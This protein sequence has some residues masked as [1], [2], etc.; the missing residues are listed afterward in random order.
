MSTIKLIN[1]II[2]TYFMYNIPKDRSSDGLFIEV[3]TFII[4]N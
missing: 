4:N 3:K 2:K 1:Q